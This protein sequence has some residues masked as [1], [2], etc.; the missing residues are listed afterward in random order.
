MD[1]VAKAYQGRI[2]IAAVD[3]HQGAGAE[4]AQRY[5]LG[6]MAMAVVF[7]DRAGSGVHRA[8][9]ITEDEARGILDRLLAEK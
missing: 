7:F 4:L 3:L 5:G 9:T 8:P 2:R 1:R 6:D